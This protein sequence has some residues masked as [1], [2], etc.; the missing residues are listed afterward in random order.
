M[1]KE[2]VS[3][4]KVDNV[5]FDLADK[6]SRIF[7][8]KVEPLQIAGAVCVVANEHIKSGGTFSAH[9]I[10][11]GTFKICIESDDVVQDDCVTARSGRQLTHRRF[12]VRLRTV[13]NFVESARSG[14]RIAP[15]VSFFPMRVLI[16]SFS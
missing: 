4:C 11:I 8:S 16:A 2:G 14:R 12:Q 9:L 15:F 7:H 10:T 6:I 5:D 3:L 1:N 13:A